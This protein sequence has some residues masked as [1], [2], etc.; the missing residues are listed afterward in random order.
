MQFFYWN[1]SFEIGIPAIDAQHRRLVDLI[2][3]LAATITDGGTQPQIARTIGDLLDY[4][5]IHFADEERFLDV[6][7]L[8]ARDKAR[9]RRAHAAFTEKVRELANRDDLHRVETAEQILEFLTTWLVAHILGADRRIVASR[10]SETPEVVV[11]DALLE[12]S[13]VER[14][15]ILALGESERRFRL[16]TDHAPALIWIAGKDGT[17]DFFNRSWLDF[18]GLGEV[19]AHQVDWR[20][21]VHPDD[22]AAYADL[23][24]SLVDDPRPAQVEYR[25]RRPSGGW[26]H[27]LEKI[28]PRRDDGGGFL[29]L[30]ASGSDVTAIKRSEELLARANRELER[31][32]A[33][34]T[35]EIERLMLTDPLTGVGNRRFLGERLEAAVERSD[36]EGRPFTVAFVDLDHF[37]AVND[38]YGHNVGDRVLGRVAG[39]LRAN[40]RENDVVARY[41]GEEFV[42][43]FPDT[44]LTSALSIAERI[45]AAV[46]R[47]RMAGLADTVG[48]SIGLAERLPGESS[49][50]LLGRADGALYRAK[51]QGRNRCLCDCTDEAGAA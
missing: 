44:S 6:S 34:R 43:V 15:L 8:G 21:L 5:A 32:V 31:E 29:G 19:E 37:K 2:N 30:I 4:A 41:G 46:S 7:D 33:R 50:L 26:A 1:A 14:V 25:V 16:I 47:I 18:A 49:C 38:H 42:V 12:V 11:D 35:A 27:V 45:R 13:S 36:R 10:S 22:L 9:H 51:R 39:T 3:A 48:V 24:T 28:L 20:T 23:L 40:L 17:R